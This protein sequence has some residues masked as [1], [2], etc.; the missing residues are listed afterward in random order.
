VS[1]T[2]NTQNIRAIILP[3][4]GSAKRTKPSGGEGVLRANGKS[5]T[6]DGGTKHTIEK[7]IRSTPPV[8]N[9]MTSKSNR[10]NPRVLCTRLILLEYKMCRSMRHIISGT[11]A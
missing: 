10:G 7:N 9:A 2:D 1:N 3:I 4:G 6:R 8:Q 5:L 11:L